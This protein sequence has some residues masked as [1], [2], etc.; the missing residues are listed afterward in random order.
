MNEELQNKVLKSL[1]EKLIKNKELYKYTRKTV[2]KN[3]HK[4]NIKFIEEVIIEAENEYKSYIKTE[5][6]DVCGGG[7]FSGYGTGYDAVCDNCG[8]QGK[9]PVW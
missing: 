3:R 2:L 4:S 5:E 7:G 1:N 8:G 6:C 9:L